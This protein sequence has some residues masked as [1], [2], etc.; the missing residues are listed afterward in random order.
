LFASPKP[1][2]FQLANQKMNSQRKA[3]AN[4]RGL[5]T[6]RHCVATEGPEGG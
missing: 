5:L 1:E 2:K 4:R 6:Y 3:R